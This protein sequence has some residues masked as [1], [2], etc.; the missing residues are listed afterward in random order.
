MGGMVNACKNGISPSIL[1]YGG[2]VVACKDHVRPSI[3]AYGWHGGSDVLI[4]AAYGWH[5]GFMQK[6]CKPS[7]LAYRWHGGRVQG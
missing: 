6:L 2:M 7:I 1:A 4:G 5:D 3:L